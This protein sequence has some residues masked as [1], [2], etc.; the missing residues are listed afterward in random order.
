MSRDT[1]LLWPHL[2]TLPAFRAVLRAIEARFYYQI[3]FPEPILD[4]GC[5]D[6]N[7]TQ[8]TF[9]GRK[10]N[11]G[12]D[13]WWNPLRKSVKAEVY[14]IA[15]QG[16]GDNMPF[17]DEHFASA[18]SNS[19]LEHIPDIQPVLNETSRVLKPGARFLI[20]MP[21]HRFT[22]CLGG[23]QMFEK[24]GLTGLA[25]SYRK[26]FNFISRHAHT[27]P[28]E[29][30]GQKLATAGF[31]VERWQ[32]YFSPKA[33][34]ALE[35]GHVQG[36]PSALIHAMMGQWILSPT[37][38]NLALT[39][40][41]VRPFY[42]EE[43]DENGTYLL[44]IAR[45]VRTGPVEFQLPPARPFT[46]AELTAGLKR[47]NPAADEPAE[48][49][50]EES[51][52]PSAR[53]V[54]EG[55]S[56]PEVTPKTE[57]SEEAPP[58]NQAGPLSPLGLLAAALLALIPAALGQST[59]ATR[60]TAFS[61]ATFWFLLSFLGLG[62]VFKAQQGF[63]WSAWW[64]STPK[65]VLAAGGGGFLSSFFAYRLVSTPGT[66]SPT[67]ALVLWGLAILVTL[68]GLWPPE[69]SSWPFGR[70]KLVWLTA[71]G[72]GGVALFLRFFGLSWHPFLLNG[73]EANIGVEANLVLNGIWRNPF[74]T[75]W[76]SNPAL[77]LYWIALPI[78]LFG[79]TVWAV[80]FWSPVMGALT[81]AL[82]YLVG[83][84]L[85][86][87]P[88][89]LTAAILLLFSHVHLHYSRL[90]LTNVWDPL[91]VL[92][93][94]GFT[95]IAW[96]EKSRAW[97]LLA[98]LALGASFYLYTSSHLILLIMLPLWLAQVV[99]D[100]AGWLANQPHW[101]AS[102]FL[103]LV[104]AL[105]QLLFFYA[106]P[107]LFFER[108]NQYGLLQT[109]SF[110]GSMGLTTLWHQF[111]TALFA[112][113][114]V[115]D[116]SLYYNPGQTL[117]GFWTGVAFVLG[118]GA[119][120]RHWRNPAYLA[121]LIWVLVVVIFAGALMVPTPASHRYLVALPAVF[122][123]ASLPVV[124][125]TELAWETIQKYRPEMAGRYTP[126]QLAFVA[127][128][129][130]AMATP[131]LLFYFGPYRTSPGMGDPNTETAFRVAQYLNTLDPSTQVYFLGEPVMYT[132]FPTLTF[133][134]PQ[135][136]PQQN[137]FDVPPVTPE[138]PLN[139]PVRPGAKSF[140]L[141][142]N[143]AMELFELQ[144]LYPNGYLNSFD[145]V[146]APQLFTIY[147]LPAE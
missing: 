132:N 124:G 95:L 70:N 129:A 40:K 74:S 100:P 20:T 45:K 140:I 103:A 104:V 144:R 60:P 145:G 39:D 36:V 58:T 29:W 66:E 6:G 8:L 101:R 11:V 128:L 43:A 108:V 44:I 22:E 73:T 126:Y 92:A 1:D 142:P 35:I 138:N 137:L 4:V 106:Y 89:G 55:E 21:N 141:L 82:T 99:L 13:P 23:A 53:P 33:L 18:Y 107:D 131:D 146:F 50:V 54:A 65:W 56:S 38:G 27:Q 134:A 71:L 9:P 90:A 119:A 49:E 84:K 91:L 147:E 51:W 52:Q 17:P 78:R 112:F 77:V 25:D 121:L 75:A 67:F 41:W 86:G 79:P 96:R 80:R 24:V 57:P 68:V 97:W 123:L 83:H 115:V 139:V 76:L 37:K 122:L 136:V 72:L 2:K 69:V 88:L 98:G 26:G 7:F 109:G 61:E 127:L 135:F 113:N 63:S 16:W 62:V 125:F 120:V 81:V 93:A 32:Y 5:G 15:V 111:F 28:A 110:A 48:D 85:W 3:P 34:H 114:G 102:Q 42:E 59:L 47:R 12:I 143:R 130:V 133:L 116:G 46:I 94:V 30:W 10:I 14:D 64:S 105:P 31:E 19:V 118:L 87:R 117:L